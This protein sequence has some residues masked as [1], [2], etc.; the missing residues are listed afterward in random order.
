MIDV[1]FNSLNGLVEL[2]RFPI[3]LQNTQN[4]IAPC[5]LNLKPMTQ[6]SGDI[7]AK[8]DHLKLSSWWGNVELANV[9]SLTSWCHGQHLIEEVFP[10]SS[11]EFSVMENE[12]NV[13]ILS[14]FR[15]LLVNISLP[16]DNIN[17]SLEE[18]FWPL[19]LNPT[20][21]V[22]LRSIQ[23]TRVVVEDSLA[24]E[25]DHYRHFR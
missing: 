4:G 15:K 8:S 22:D 18:S 12:Q 13:T 25:L 20:T 5:C 2:L 24:T 7:T 1:N 11:T 9:S 3:S 6:T 14:P 23:E 19:L 21:S 17:E 16:T 10:G